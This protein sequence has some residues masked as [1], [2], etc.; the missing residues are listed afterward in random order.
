M[1]I[2][3]EVTLTPNLMNALT[4]PILAALGLLGSL[5]AQHGGIAL[6]LGMAVASLSGGRQIRHAST[7]S[8][9]ALQIGV[10]LLGLGL[11]L[12][13][14][15]SIGRR[16]IVLVAI[17]VVVTLLLGYLLGRL[18]R[19]DDKESR[20]LAGGTAICG[21]TAVVTLAPAIGASGRQVSHVLPVIYVLNAIA[22]ALFPLIGEALQLSAHQFGLWCAMAIHDTAAVVGSAAIHG[23]EALAT[24][25]TV[26]LM[27]VLWLIP[28]VWVYAMS[29]S[30]GGT[31]LKLPL[32]IV[33]F[34][35][36]SVL[37]SVW[38]LP[39]EL[40][41]IAQLVSRSLFCIAIFLIGAR[42]SLGALLQIPKRMMTQA[43]LLW[44]TL[45]AGSLSAIVLTQ[46]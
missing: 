3:I 4:F 18:L 28:V 43:T 34:L 9:Y 7:M 27:R 46:S 22:M 25:T 21:G 1:I 6:L 30:E 44:L 40:L 17:S 24:A 16:S 2:A 11:S 32:F 38:P 19:C 37:G 8:T 12:G 23:N 13:E 26:K 33:G 14:L 39:A 36:A 5:L 45:S 41:D 20:L 29:A 42:L 15:N 31:K 10:V 35:L